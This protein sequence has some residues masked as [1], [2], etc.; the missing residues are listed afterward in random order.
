MSSMVIRRGLA[1]KPVAAG[2]ITKTQMFN[3]GTAALGCPS[4]EARPRESSASGRA[5]F[6]AA[7]ALSRSG[8]F[9]PSQL[10]LFQSLL[11]RVEL[12]ALLRIHLRILQIQRF[13]RIHDDRRDYQ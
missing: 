9:S 2:H 10:F 12:L 3:V 7:L 5:A 4:G 6:R 8:A 11:R 13:Q 1:A